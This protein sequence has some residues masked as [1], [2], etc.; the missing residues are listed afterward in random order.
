MSF[1]ITRLTWKIIWH[2]T[3]SL[4]TRVGHMSVQ[5]VGISLLSK[6]IL[7]HTLSLYTWVGNFHV[8]PVG[9]SSQ[10]EAVLQA[11]RNQ[12]TWALHILARYVATKQPRNITW[13]G[14]TRSHIPP[15]YNDIQVHQQI[16]FNINVQY[17][18]EYQNH[19]LNF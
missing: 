9:I 8:M 7:L 4:G 16:Y 10:Q 1:V 12:C 17:S 14:I 5:N 3:V 11:I 19:E 18:G 15:L 2:G 6:V 13:L